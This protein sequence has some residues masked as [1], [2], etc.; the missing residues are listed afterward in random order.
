MVHKFKMSFYKKNKY[1]IILFVV[2]SILVYV[3]YNKP[4]PIDWS[5]TFSSTD[6]I[7]YGTFVLREELKAAFPE[8]E[9]KENNRS[10]FQLFKEEIEAPILVINNEFSP[11]ELDLKLLLNH[12]DKGYDLFIA[13][14]YFSTEFADTLGFERS[15]NVK[16]I[17]F[18]DSISELHF[19]NKKLAGEK[20]IY[21]KAITNSIFTTLDTLRTTILGKSR[22]GTNFVK[23]KH[24]KGNV[25]I[26]LEP[27]VF[28]NYNLLTEK[29]FQYAFKALSYLPY[30]EIIWDE[31]YKI[32]SGGGS[33]SGVG[34]TPMYFI[35][36]NPPLRYA[37][38]ILLLGMIIYILFE[39]KRLQRII[40]V[41]NPPK[42]TSLEFIE[43]IG[44]LYFHR[45]SHK[46]LAEKKF[47]Y[48]ADYLRTN[49]NLKSNS[50][51]TEHYSKIAEKTGTNKIL[52]GNIF[53]KYRHISAKAYIAEQELFDLNKEI[54]CFYS[55]CK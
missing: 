33:S 22:R 41:I 11:S 30:G 44:K 25:F 46:D 16:S 2:F 32:G 31:Y 3:E 40:P 19:T 37:W 6:K 51:S 38:Y 34:K 43:T 5:Q 18:S 13:A 15:F 27:M 42:N 23:I 36:E 8:K 54:E 39:G 17:L 50:F 35:L 9:I 28:T 7:P 4:K 21:K 14:T 45:A 55:K 29:N 10:Y 24:G 26:H 52:I 47:K 12:V 1:Y 49:Y 53:N 48:F 20:Y